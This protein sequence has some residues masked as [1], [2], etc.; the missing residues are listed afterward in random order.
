MAS[1]IIESHMGEPKADRR[2]NKVSCF[3]HSYY[4]WTVDEQQVDRTERRLSDLSTPT[5][6]LQTV[7]HRHSSST[8]GSSR[9]ECLWVKMSEVICI[10]V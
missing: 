2:R 6:E 8:Q 5:D 3:Q 9:L 7:L 4:Y 10:D 1:I